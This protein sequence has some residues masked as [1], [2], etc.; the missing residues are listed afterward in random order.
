ML[1]YKL[2]D[3]DDLGAL[4]SPFRRQI[5]EE[6]S[7]GPDSAANIAR[8]HDMSRQ[9]VGYH[10]RDLEKAG[11]IQVVEERQQRGLKERLYGVRPVA[12]V[13]GQPASAEPIQDRFSW[14]SLINSLAQ[15]LWE[16]VTLRRLAD[17]SNKRLATLGVEGRIRFKTPQERKAFTEELVKEIDRLVRKYDSAEAEKGRDF[18][19][20]VASFPVLDSGGKQDDTQH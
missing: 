20:L 11:Y 3:N 2:L 17:A 15:S 19:L 14:A 4:A 10:M 12:Y 9:R 1:Q 5:L 6:L 7:D 16:L 18:K 13:R 8:R